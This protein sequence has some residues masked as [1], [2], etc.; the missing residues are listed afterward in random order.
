MKTPLQEYIR[1][2]EKFFESPAEILEHPELTNEDMLV[3]L[4]S[5]Q[6]DLMELQ[7]ANDENMSRKAK[8]EGVP[9][10]DTLREVI[11]AIRLLER[12]KTRSGM[13]APVPRPDFDE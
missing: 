5:W 9:S 2:P 11:R 3:L 12:S 6:N 1:S 13:I 10:A 8:R 4:S 7:F